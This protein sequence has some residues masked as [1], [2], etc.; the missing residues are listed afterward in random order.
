MMNNIFKFTSLAALALSGS[1][2][3]IERLSPIQEPVAQPKQAKQAETVAKAWLGV[4]GKSVNP[5]LAAQL[6]I[7]HGVTVEL[8]A[9][10]GSAAKSGIKKFDIITKIGDREIKGMDDLRA[11]IVDA[12]VDQ[13]L[14]IELFSSGK[15]VTKKVKLEARPDHLP[16]YRTDPTPLKSGQAHSHSFKQLPGA[17]KHL[18]QAD[19]QRI[20]NMVQSQVQQLENI[21]SQMDIEEADVAKMK[22]KIKSMQLDLGEIRMRGHSN[23]SGTFTMMDD[24]GSIRLKVTD[25]AG[26]QVEVKDKSGKVLYAGPYETAEDKAAV[27]ADVRAR[28]DALG[29]DSHAQGNGFKFQFGE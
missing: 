14:D 10:D 16:K 25:A 12:E 6:N 18:P 21:F 3:A 8:V 13:T 17:L 26:K 20:Q 5:A 19:Q 11:A 9:G 29:L 22:E 1:G 15:K 28:I 7:S 27:P 24:Q 4:A 23:F 2:Y